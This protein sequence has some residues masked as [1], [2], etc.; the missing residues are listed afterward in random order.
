M[1][2]PASA[3]TSFVPAAATGLT[4]PVWAELKQATM[5][6]ADI[7]SSTEQIAGLDPEQAMTRLRPAVMQMCAA[8]ESFGGTVV[9]TLGDGVMAVFGIPSTLEGHGRLACEA[10]L[11]MQAVFNDNPQGLRIRVGLHSGLVASDPQDHDVT[12]GGGVY[13]HAVHLASR[14]VGL[15]EPGA[16]CLTAACLALLRRQ[17]WVRSIGFQ[18]LKGIPDA[19]E[20]FVLGGLSNVS[21]RS[22][23]HET[24]VS[25]FRG[26]ARELAILQ[27]SLTQA[28]AGQGAVVG[29]CGAPGAGKS[30]LSHEFAENCRRQG[31]PVVEVR[32][33]LYGHVTPLLPLLALLRTWI[34]QVTPGD[35][36]EH[37]RRQVADQLS[38]L[39][40]VLADDYALMCEFLSV[41]DAQ[42]PACALEPKARR[43]RLLVLLKAMFRQAG[44]SPVAIVF[45]DLHWLD[46]A[47][48]VFLSAL[49]EG[50]ADSHIVLLLNYRPSYSAPWLH[51]T[52]FQQLTVA[53]LSPEDTTALVHELL[54]THPQL[55]EAV[56]V[57]VERSAGNPFF[58][59]EL[60]HSLV[61]SAELT[62]KNG[63]A[64]VL[65]A[66]PVTVQAVIGE[67]IDRLFVTQKNLLH[68]CAVIGKEIPLPV[69]KQ[70]AVYLASQLEIGLDGLCE[71]ELLQMLRA[72]TD[73]RRYA[74][75]HPLIQEVAY[76]SQ[77]KARRAE[78]H[79]S[80]AV[81]MVNFYRHQLDEYAALIAHHSEAAGR[82]VEAAQYLARAAEWMGAANSTQAMVHWR[83]ARALLQDQPRAPDTD[84][85]RVK[86]GAGLVYLGWRE[87]MSAQEVREVVAETVALA[88]EVDNRLVQLLYL[89]EGRI[90]Q[91]TGGAAD[92][93][94]GKLLTAMDLGANAGDVGRLAAMNSALSHA[95]SWSGLLNEGL[96]ANDAALSGVEHLDPRDIEFFGF[97][98]H[99]WVL[100]VRARILVRMGRLDDMRLCMA[101]LLKTLHPD[102][103]PVIRQ[104]SYLLQ[105]EMGSALKQMDIVHEAAAEVA[106]IAAVSASP[107][108]KIINFWVQGQAQNAQNRHEAAAQDF[109]D[110]LAVIRSTGVGRDIEVEVLVG[111]AEC[112]AELG[113][114]EK[115]LLHAKDALTL[116]RQRNN[117]VSECRALMVYGGVLV[118]LNGA[119]ASDEAELALAQA[120]QLITVTGAK[121]HEPAFARV[122]NQRHPG[123]TRGSSV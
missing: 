109:S 27:Q 9:R 87:G 74:F 97:D 43:A 33:Q 15:A 117:R 16:V 14:V 36:A 115:A 64:S 22:H 122:L 67:R 57:I 45:E 123:M 23:F 120:A 12:I 6:F 85:L 84:R 75:R 76:G 21:T 1:T 121:L 28:K 93:Y 103:D 101:A 110:A 72:L 3:E 70:V 41:A 13:G 19:T 81:A 54:A 25:A 114:C 20:I 98:I 111:L 11:A 32:S 52:Q 26:R 10:A 116:S 79:G 94:V 66:L 89:A 7:V 90:L 18:R 77:L 39:G 83:K 61:E 104:V 34:F 73:G 46:D 8:I 48:E 112:C 82:P 113:D 29:L 31:M 118:R 80:V 2:Q 99:Q 50:L 44:S 58:A 62:A 107:Y 68:I 56:S 38:R 49:I 17:C 47:S 100:M 106:R 63:L 108:T 35:T 37:A 69:L 92:D 30:R 91:G 40:P 65:Q 86:I 51:L 88:T 105:V 24:R 119:S 95:Y 4:E 42:A 53:E 60:V 71:A 96:A 78:V 59:E 5:L 55:H 102:H